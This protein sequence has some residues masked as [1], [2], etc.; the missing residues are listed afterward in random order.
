MLMCKTHPVCVIFN[1]INISCGLC[2]EQNITTC[3]C[4]SI[5]ATPDDQVVKV[6]DELRMVGLPDDIDI[7]ALFEPTGI[8]HIFFTYS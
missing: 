5:E 3:T 7:Q 2:R 4:I 6:W 1:Y 8:L